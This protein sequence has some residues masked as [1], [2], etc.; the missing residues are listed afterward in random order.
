LLAT[1]SSDP[2]DEHPQEEIRDM[3]SGNLSNL[4]KSDPP[5]SWSPDVA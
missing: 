5:A 4:K 2:S 1:Q 3:M